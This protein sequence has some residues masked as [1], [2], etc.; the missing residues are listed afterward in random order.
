MM[1]IREDQSI[2]ELM[3]LQKII[4]DI[5]TSNYDES[6]FR[7]K[8]LGYFTAERHQSVI[9]EILK[10][11]FIFTHTKMEIF[12]K[13]LQHISNE[14]EIKTY[15]SFHAKQRPHW[16]FIGFASR[17]VELGL[18]DNQ[19]L[20]EMIYEENPLLDALMTD[21]IEKFQE[22]VSEPGFDANKTEIEIRYLGGKIK[23]YPLLCAICKFGAV[24]CF[25]HYMMNYFDEY[26]VDERDV[27]QR[28]IWGRNI[29]IIRI[30]IQNH[31]SIQF[32]NAQLAIMT[33]NKELLDWIVE[34]H[35]KALEIFEFDCFDN[36]F[37]EVIS[38]KWPYCIEEMSDNFSKYVKYDYYD[39]AC[40]VIK[41]SGFS[42]K[43][44]EIAKTSGNL[45]IA[46]F[47][48]EHFTDYFVRNFDEYFDKIINTFDLAL[49]E[50]LVQNEFVPKDFRYYNRFNK[51]PDFM[52]PS[53]TIKEFTSNLLKERE[54]YYIDIFIYYG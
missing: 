52:T 15:L 39:A 46:K 25:K 23:H 10:A 42:I 36:L 33:R 9:V 37:L 4:L 6:M 53:P 47:F 18:L 44:A 14:F 1:D 41:N 28:A 7:I 54:Q 27:M 43:H 11:G 35:P 48:T 3:E 2:V 22:I 5:S 30:L 12:I 45:K 19:D 26:Y 20:D 29:E 13:I 8:E 50:Y 17:L 51:L 49:L 21:D 24:K 38:E 32:E 31:F 34:Q 16:F 40:F